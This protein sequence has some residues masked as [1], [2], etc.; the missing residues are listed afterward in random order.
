[1]TPVGQLVSVAL[2]HR[3]G[4]RSWRLAREVDPA[5]LREVSEADVGP[6]V[7]LVFKATHAG[8][9]TLAFALTRG[10][11]ATAADSRSYVVRVV[12]G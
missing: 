11:R 9:V 8:N 7:V 3:P 4:G 6:A 5:I 10:E 2:S 12:S 1:V